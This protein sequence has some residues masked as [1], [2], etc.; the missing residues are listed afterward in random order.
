MRY[1]FAG[2]L[3]GDDS[4]FPAWRGLRLRF[5]EALEDAKKGYCAWA[6][7]NFDEADE[8]LQKWLSEYT[9]VYRKHP[10]TLPF[11]R[12]YIAYKA[13]IERACPR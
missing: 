8:A 12:D 10:S 11:W 3:G 4:G 6:L 9:Q 13:Q 1:T 2:L 5:E 7:M